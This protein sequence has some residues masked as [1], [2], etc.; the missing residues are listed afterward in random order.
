MPLGRN[1]WDE[2]R[3]R[4]LYLE[5]LFD[6]IRYDIQL[7]YFAH[8][9][10]F[11]NSQRQPHV[12]RMTLRQQQSF[13]TYLHTDMQ[14]TLWVNEELRRGA[15]HRSGQQAAALRRMLRERRQM[16]S[17]DLRAN[18][19]RGVGA[20]GTW[21]PC[22]PTPSAP[23]K[24]PRTG[25]PR[26]TVRSHTAESHRSYHLQ[27]LDAAQP[28]QKDAHRKLSFAKNNAFWENPEKNW[29]QFSK[30]QAKF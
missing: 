1:P 25:S 9:N 29:L 22:P 6:N 24:R 20:G 18:P 12:V 7:D 3:A 10:N 8:R 4:V 13:L 27:N 30:N 15:L 17:E 14:S 26:F 21:K 11:L 23:R 19:P 2:E 28:R 16:A 5:R